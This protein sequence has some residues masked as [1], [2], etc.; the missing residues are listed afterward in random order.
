MDAAA[1]RAALLALRAQITEL[2]D[3]LDGEA[4]IDGRI[5]R[6][7]R[8]LAA[9]IPEDLPTQAQV[10]QLAHQLERLKS[11]GNTVS[12]EWPDFL[13]SG[14]L[15]TT[16]A[17]DRT[18]R[19][20]AEWRAFKKNAEK[21]SLTEAQVADAVK[22]AA[23]LATALREVEASEFV[24]PEIPDEFN[25]MSRQ[26]DAVRDE[27]REDRLPAAPSANTLPLDMVTSAEN[28]VKKLA[29][30]ATAAGSEV[31]GVAYQSG[32]EF[33][34]EA[35]DSTIKEA[36]NQGKKVGPALFKWARRVLVSA[37]ALAGAKATGLGLVIANLMQQFPAVAEWL[38]PVIRILS[39]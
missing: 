7:L 24:A 38:G 31:K 10:F 23:D 14:F 27:A 32:A 4:N 17:F 33:A 28:F 26:L 25:S 1:F 11:Y 21:E 3:E 36:G 35:K 39:H 12:T 34:R 8:R 20:Y 16:R 18:V 29:E 15:A 19:Q 5:V 30:V 13:A 22:I 2:A 37:G 6:F 9:Q